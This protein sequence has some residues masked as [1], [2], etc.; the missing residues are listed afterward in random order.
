MPDNRRDMAQQLKQETRDIFRPRRNQTLGDKPFFFR[1]AENAD[2]L[3]K[4]LQ[5][6]KYNSYTM[7][8]TDKAG[9]PIFGLSWDFKPDSD[10]SKW[11]KRGLVI[12]LARDQRDAVQAIIE[13]VMNAKG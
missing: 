7:G 3:S 5:S 2:H 12:V 4:W 8:S 10:W 11:E 6:R 9:N 13:Q 1:K